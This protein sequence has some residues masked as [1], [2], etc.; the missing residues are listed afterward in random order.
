M[1]NCV[2]GFNGFYLNPVDPP[3]MVRRKPEVSRNL[4]DTLAVP[5][6]FNISLQT[7]GELVCSRKFF[8]IL[9]RFRRGVI[10]DRFFGQPSTVR[11]TPTCLGYIDRC[12]LC[13]IT[14]MNL[15]SSN[16]SK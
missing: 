11:P 12:V 9:L 7:D 1:K 13:R 4:V 15:G 2:T 8:K 5:R 3:E 14:S 6:F 10:N 16:P